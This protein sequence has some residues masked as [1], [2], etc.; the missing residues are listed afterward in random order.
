MQQNDKT[1]FVFLTSHAFSGST[2]SSFLLGAHPE[3]ATAGMLTGPAYHLNLDTYRCS[4]G[5][6]FQECPFW[7]QVTQVVNKYGLNYSLNQYLDTRFELGRSELTRRLR[8]KSLRYNRLEHL[9]DACVETFWPGHHLEMEQCLRRNEIFARAITEVSGK[10]FFLDTSKDP[11][12]IRFLRR[13]T[14][15]DFYVIHLVR[16]VRGVVTSIMSRRSEMT[17]KQAARHWLQCEQNIKRQLVDVPPER[18]ILVQYEDLVADTLTTLNRIFAFLGISQLNDI[19]N[20]HQKE[21]HIFGNKMRKASTSEIKQDERWRTFLSPTQ[22]QTIQ[23]T[24][25]DLAVS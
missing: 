15:L 9:R 20:Y 13:S 5:N 7:L 4:C 24:V 22:L 19:S 11:M 17:I 12:R 10:P 14:Q 8:T 23:K 2:L 25:G 21:Q 6:L 1:P 16:D 18:Q 3:I